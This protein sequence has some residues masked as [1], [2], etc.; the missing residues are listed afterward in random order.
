MRKKYPQTE[1]N[2]RFSPLPPPAPLAPSAVFLPDLA[3]RF[4]LRILAPPAPEARSREE[5]KAAARHHLSAL[6][7]SAL[8]P[9]LLLTSSQWLPLF[10]PR[11]YPSPD[12]APSASGRTCRRSTRVHASLHPL[13][14]PRAHLA[15]YAELLSGRGTLRAPREQRYSCSFAY[16]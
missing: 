5:I 13:Q 9:E 11:S 6:I 10:R 7:L 1:S 14:I 3:P 15:Q 8:P 2:F 16:G 12:F 4:S